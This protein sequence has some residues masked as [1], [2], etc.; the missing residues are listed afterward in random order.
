MKRSIVFIVCILSLLTSC[1]KKEQLTSVDFGSGEFE[2]PFRGLLA[3]HPSWLVATLDWPVLRSLKSDTVILSKTIEVGFNEDAIRSNSSARLFFVDENGYSSNKYQVFCNQELVGLEGYE[4]K[5]SSEPQRLMLSVKIDPSIGDSTAIGYISII[6]H[7]IDEV[8]TIPLTE[9]GS[10]NIAQWSFYHEIGWPMLIW[11]IWLLLFLLLVAIVVGILYLLGLLFVEIGEG[12]TALLKMISTIHIKMPTRQRTTN[13]RNHRNKNNN[14]DDDDTNKR[15]KK[16]WW[17][18]Y[19]CY[20]YL[21]STSIHAKSVNLFKLMVALENLKKLNELYSNDAFF[22]LP[23]LVQGDLDC[24][25]EKINNNSNGDPSRICYY[26][27]PSDT[28]CLY[29]TDDGEKYAEIATIFDWYK[30]D[31]KVFSLRL[32]NKFKYNHGKLDLSGIAI[33]KVTVKYEIT[34]CQRYGSNGI[35]PIAADLFMQNKKFVRKM[36]KMGYDDFW[37]FMNGQKKDKFGQERFIRKTPLLLHEDADC[38][39]IYIV[40]ALIHQQLRHYGGISMAQIVNHSF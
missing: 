23:S 24:L 12:A 22:Q 28:R 3:S 31:F 16:Y 21:A 9:E 26:T 7:E 29:S 4:I 36:K 25:W 34:N 38:K 11:I 10:Q 17:I 35:Q 27:I 18:K 5:A 15:K 2:E 8:N 40:P 32:H 39:T 37:Y 33:A 14:N 1:Q 13:I 20:K 19:R 6:G 30:N